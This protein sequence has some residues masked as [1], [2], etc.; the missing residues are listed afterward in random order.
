VALGL[1]LNACGMV[2]GMDFDRERQ[3]YFEAYRFVS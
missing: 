1:E 2:V 3:T